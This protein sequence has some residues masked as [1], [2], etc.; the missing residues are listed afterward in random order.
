[1]LR[2]TTD[3]ATLE[4]RKLQLNDGATTCNQDAMPIVIYLHLFK[5]TAIIFHGLLNARIS[6]RC[7]L[8]LLFALLFTG[9]TVVTL[10]K[11]L[12]LWHL[13]K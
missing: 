5:I 1:M 12:L 10:I 9:C 6:D 3:M 13:F 8:A 4:S 7:H 11:S 2:S